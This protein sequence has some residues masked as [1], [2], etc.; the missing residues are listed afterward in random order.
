MKFRRIYILWALTAL[1]LVGLI[2]YPRLVNLQPYWVL[3][4]MTALFYAIL[5]SSW[6][7]LAG[8]TGQFSFAHMA[9]MGLGTYAAGI[10][11][12][13]MG[14]APWQ[15]T[16]GGVLITGVVGLIIGYLCLRL[17]AVYL[18]LFTIAFA[19]IF[20]L[21]VKAEVKFTGGPNGLELPTYTFPGWLQNLLRTIVPFWDANVYIP[22]YYT[23]AFLF[24]AALLFMFL[25]VRSRFGI[26][27][28]AVREDEE[29]AAALGVHVVNTRVLAFV[30]SSMIAG[31]AGIVFHHFI[32]LIVP[33]Q[34]Q[35]GRMSLIIAMA[36]I[37]GSQNLIGAALG[38]IFIHFSLEWLQQIPLPTAVLQH[39][40]FLNDWGFSVDLH[41]GVLRTNAWRMVGF[42][43]LLMLTLRFWQNGLISPI[44][45]WLARREAVESVA[46]RFQAERDMD[47]VDD[48]Q[49]IGSQAEAGNPQEPTS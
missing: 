17:R 23:M 30:V 13:D 1:F 27:F 46:Q 7:L 28:R 36:V 2:F 26:F 3:V 4:G 24:V 12:R 11:I 37:G 34:M 10:L 5:A 29:A 47:A 21:V 42:G 15:A 16:I 14:F 49:A 45:D 33:D 43:L 39:L 22:A 41:A 31:F 35:I 32:G 25:L 44:I 18:A 38:A 48:V 40:L 19:E 9:F 20:R 6:S 8:Y